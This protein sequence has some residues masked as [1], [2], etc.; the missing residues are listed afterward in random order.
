[1]RLAFDPAK[2][3]ANR[4]KHGLSLTNAARFDWAA[5]EFVPDICRDYGEAR[6]QVYGNIDGRLHVLVVTPRDGELRAISLRK[7]NKREIR[8]HGRRQAAQP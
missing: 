7:A 6:F 3:G 5:V 1:M 8:E 4:A 2:D